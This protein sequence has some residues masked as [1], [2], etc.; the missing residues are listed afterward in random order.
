MDMAKREAQRRAAQGLPPLSNMD[1]GTT[2]NSGGYTAGY[3]SVPRYD[4]PSPV[5]RTESPKSSKPASFKGKGMKL[6]ATKKLR[7]DEMVG[8]LG[9]EVDAPAHAVASSSSSRG[10]APTQ[11]SVPAVAKEKYM[12]IHSDFS[13]ITNPYLQRPHSNSR[14]SVCSARPRFFSRVP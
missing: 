4:A 6:G 8:S 10:V 1:F 14:A 2:P 11:R 13:I 3:S 7:Q 5:P 12:T 9:A